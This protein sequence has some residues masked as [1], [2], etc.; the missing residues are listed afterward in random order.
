MI[1][2]VFYKAKGIKIEVKRVGLFSKGIGLTFRTSK[3][4]NLLFDF[5]RDTRMSITSYFVFFPFLAIWLDDK[6]RV[7]HKEII[8]PFRFNVAPKKAFRK[9]I[10]VPVNK[11]NS[12]ILAFFRR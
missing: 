1:E 8:N 5:K 11:R 2:T 6:N 9:L 10:E 12:K 4:K 7:I 3:T